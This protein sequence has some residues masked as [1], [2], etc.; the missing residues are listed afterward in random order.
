M[1]GNIAEHRIPVVLLPAD[2]D[3]P[4]SFRNSALDTGS[5]RFP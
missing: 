5:D 1:R 4:A 2:T 3:C